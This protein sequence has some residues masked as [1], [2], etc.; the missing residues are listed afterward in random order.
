MISLIK[1]Y[2]KLA[3]EYIYILN[4]IFKYLLIIQ[5]LLGD[6]LVEYIYEN[7]YN[8]AVSSKRKKYK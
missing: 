6:Y 3:K 8:N 7:I 5:T 4:I 2:W 1:I